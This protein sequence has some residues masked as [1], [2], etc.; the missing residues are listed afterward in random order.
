MKLDR[1]AILAPG[2]LGGSLALAVR[3]RH[4]HISLSIYA[5]RPSVINEMKEACLDADY[6]TDPILAIQN[7]DLVVFCMTIDAMP[8]IAKRIRQGFKENAIV[9]DVGSVKERLDQEMQKIFENPEAPTVRWIGGHPMAGGEKTGFGAA[10]ATL[11]ESSTTILT[12]TEH[13]DTEALL[14]LKEFW[15]SL[16]S[17]VLLCTPHEHD[18]RVAQISHLT[19]LTASALVHSVSAESIEARGPGFR[20]T[21]RV[22]AG[23]PLMWTEILLQNKEAVLDAIQRL[24]R[25]LSTIESH[26]QNS[27]TKKITH[28]LEKSAEI[29]SRLNY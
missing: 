21:T 17:K 1:I 16:G 13:S 3:Q 20:D 11:F 28:W 7:A 6:F 8:A 18:Q 14:F 12:P 29:R 24:Q 5:R 19:H 22:A 10:H 25:E 2:L 27:E 26:L 4:P 23:S 9:T 15:S